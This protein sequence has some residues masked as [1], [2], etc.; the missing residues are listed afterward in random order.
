MKLSSAVSELR[1]QEPARL[2]VHCRFERR[3][4]DEQ[5]GAG[6]GLTQAPGRPRV[7]GEHQPPPRAAGQH[8]APGVVAVVDADRGNVLQAYGGT[9]RFGI[10]Q[11]LKHVGQYSRTSMTRSLT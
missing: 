4:V 6:A 10:S 2:R 11:G 1:S 9:D 5:S 3:L 7:A 8:E